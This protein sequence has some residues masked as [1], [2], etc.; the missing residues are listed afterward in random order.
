MQQIFN[1]IEELKKLSGNAQLDFLSQYK[2]NTT[3]CEVLL[4]TYDTDKK[5]KIKEA[6]LD[7]AFEKYYAQLRLSEVVSY[8]NVDNSCW[9]KFKVS[10][11]RLLNARGVKESEIESLV[12]EFYFKKL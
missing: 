3:L 1:T 6:S 5:F 9:Q 10:L 8:S 12:K 7:K 2:D 4:F 11:E